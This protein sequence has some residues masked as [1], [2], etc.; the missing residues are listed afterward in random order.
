MKPTFTFQNKSYQAMLF[1]MDGT[2]IDNMMVHHEA[3]RVA[4]AE[5]GVHMTLDEVK[6]EIHGVNIEILARLFGDSFSNAEAEQFAFNKE[7][8]YRRIYAD[9]IELI[10][11]AKEFLDKAQT[12]KIPMAVATAAP[13]ENIN[14]VLEHLPISHYFSAVKHAGDVSRG[15]PDPE[16]FQLAA[17]ALKVDVQECLVFEDSVTGAMAAKNAGADAII[18]TTTHEVREFSEIDN[19]KTFSHNY[20]GLIDGL[21]STAN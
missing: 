9:K 17:K 14:F 6:A 18:I 10:S 21:L 3:W 2:L 8:A 1:D 5:K 12:L 16:V 4:L 7:A 19:I 20:E 13:F 15:K 11:G